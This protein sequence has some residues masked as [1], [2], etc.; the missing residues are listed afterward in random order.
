MYPQLV[1]IY[2]SLLC[3]LPPILLL[4]NMSNRI[5]TINANGLNSTYKRSRLWREAIIKKTDILCV[6]EMHFIQDKTPPCQHRL[7]PRTYFAHN[8][9]K[10]RGVMIAIRKSLS[11]QLGHLETDPCGRYLIL[12]VLFDNIPYVIANIQYMHPT[13]TKNNSTK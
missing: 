4:I 5:T 10:R 7:Y 2:T 1:S 8:N 6:R 3:T 9:K 12:D 13:L 11:F